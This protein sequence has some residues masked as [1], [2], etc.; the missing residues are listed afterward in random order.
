[1]LPMPR[2]YVVFD[3]NVYRTLGADRFTKLRKSERAH[4]VIGRAS[5]W[6]IHE[7][8][9][10]L[11]NREDAAFARSL[12]ALRR[13]AEHC[14]YY[15]GSRTVVGFLGDTE[16]HLD[17]I[18]FQIPSTRDEAQAYGQ[19]IGALVSAAT[20][21]DWKP[22]QAAI[23][24]I[25]ENVVRLEE[26]N[27][28]RFRRILASMNGK[29]G[30][31]DAIRRTT[32]L[33]DAIA[34]MILSQAGMQGAAEMMVRSAAMRRGLTLSEETECELVERMLTIFPFQLRLYN[35]VAARVVREGIDM[36]GSANR[37]WVWDWMVAFSTSVVA[38][39]D[40]IPIW[41]V[42]DDTL[43]LDAASAS[44]P[45]S[46]VRSLT[47]YEAVLELLPQEFARAIASTV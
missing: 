32:G 30:A 24:Q 31:S 28:E 4:S 36:G 27:V 20:P 42:T 23:E 14:S 8:V 7:L 10:H 26:A 33:A 2:L 46:V 11:A 41:L 39:V 9:A 6:V 16:E 5:Y 21:D 29:L 13:L 3:T 12:A 40:G 45:R 37:N 1:M 15:D 44:G 38:H 25:A 17:E 18:I 19:L 47:Q 22:Y 43:I 35:A 34:K